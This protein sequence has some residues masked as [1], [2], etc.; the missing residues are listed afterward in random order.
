MLCVRRDFMHLVFDESASDKG[1][2]IKGVF[3]GFL[4]YRLWLS[5]L[6]STV[7]SLGVFS[8]SS[9]IQTEYELWISFMTWSLHYRWAGFR[10]GHFVRYT[11]MLT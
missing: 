10:I 8:S 2:V 1:S 7:P 6:L 11:P 4:A 3:M 5:C 9:C